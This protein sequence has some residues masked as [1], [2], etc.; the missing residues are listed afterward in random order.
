MPAIESCTLVGMLPT[1]TDGG[2]SSK[3]A[4]VKDTLFQW[5]L[6]T[7]ISTTVSRS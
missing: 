1:W 5:K 6:S 7:A 4:A 3:V 2:H